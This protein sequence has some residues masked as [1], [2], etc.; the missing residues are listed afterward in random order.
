M[1]RDHRV[2][3]L[4]QHRVVVAD[5]ALEQRLSGAKSGEQVAAHFLLDRF[6]LVPARAKLANGLRP[7]WGHSKHYSQGAR[8]VQRETADHR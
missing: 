7:A 3:Q 6:V 2:G 8:H 4:R 5:D 1:A